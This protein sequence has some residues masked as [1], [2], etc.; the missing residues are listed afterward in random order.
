MLLA[1]PLKE[2]AIFGLNFYNFG[3]VRNMSD[4]YNPAYIKAQGPDG[5]YLGPDKLLHDQMSQMMH[6]RNV[7]IKDPRIK[8]D[9]KIVE[10]LCSDDLAKRIDKFKKLPKILHFTQ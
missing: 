1:C 9:D 2:L 4:K 5:T 6:C 8:M 10:T 7:L 3:I